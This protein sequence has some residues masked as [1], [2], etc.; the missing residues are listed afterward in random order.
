MIPT[1]GNLTPPPQAL[2][3]VFDLL[4]VPLHKAFVLLLLLLLRFLLLLG[5]DIENAL[6]KGR[7]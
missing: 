6:E 2:T 4:L 5:F 7:M 3:K 1:N